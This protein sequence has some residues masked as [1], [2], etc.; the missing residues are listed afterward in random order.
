ML[1]ITGDKIRVDLNKRTVN[2]MISDDEIKLR[3]EELQKNGGFKI[4]ESQ[5]RKY[6]DVIDDFILTIISMARD[7]SE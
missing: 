3:R 7:I 2:V 1:T 5:T 4:P 6:K